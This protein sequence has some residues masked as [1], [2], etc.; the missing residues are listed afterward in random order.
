MQTAHSQTFARSDLGVRPAE[1]SDRPA[2]V[3]IAAQTWDGEDYLPRVLDAWYADPHGGFYVA[4]IEGQVVGVTKVTRLA[5]E[6]WWLEGLRVRPGYEGNG[7]ARILHHFALNQVRSLGSGVVR[8]STASDNAPIHMLARETGFER[9]ARFV[10]YTAEALADDAPR[11]ARLMPDDLPRVA[12]WLA[13]SEHFERAGRS[14]GLGWSFTLLTEARLR[15]RLAA[16]QVFGWPADVGALAGVVMLAGPEEGHSPPKGRL[17]AGYLDAGPDVLTEMARALR[18]LAADQGQAAVDVLAPQHPPFTGALEAAGFRRG[19]D[20]EVWLFARD[21]SLTLY[22]DV[23]V[24]DP[25][26]DD[27]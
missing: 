23:R 16:G 2:L 3:A 22:A 19:W 13:V 5:D 21:I 25:S 10:P 11:L 14:F 6:E 15:E 12:G 1:L 26:P 18:R 9:V 27:R 4:T 20:G 8:F 17:R 7:I 24:E